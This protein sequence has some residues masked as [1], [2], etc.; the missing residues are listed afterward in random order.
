MDIKEY[1]VEV[2]LDK[3]NHPWE[4]A[5]FEVVI[6]LLESCL[7][8]KGKTFNIVDI[9]C[10]DA[11]FLHQLSKRFENCHYFAVDTAFSSDILCSFQE[12]YKNT[13]MKFYQNISDVSSDCDKIDLILLLDVIEHVENDVAL[14]S[15]LHTLPGFYSETIV[16]ITAPAYQSL[17]CSHDEW[18][19]HYRRYSVKMLRQHLHQAGFTPIK[20]GYFF[21]T[22]L[23]PRIFQKNKERFVKSNANN[24]AGIGDWT[25]G[26]FLSTVLKNILIADYKFSNIFR[27]M[28]I[29]FS[30]LSCYC[31]SKLN[32]I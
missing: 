10:G 14:L 6:D 9:G 30:G 13:N 25:G 17:F 22:L 4:Y 28:G 8:K 29:K 18:L 3:Q 21:F 31:I 15:S 27:R 1:N 16:V 26:R 11:F 32:S 2:A 19:G 7:K 12:K 20:S 5:R 24:V 23:L